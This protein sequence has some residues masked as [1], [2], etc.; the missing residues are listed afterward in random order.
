MA[1]SQVSTPPYSIHPHDSRVRSAGSILESLNEID[2]HSE[3][4]G[5]TLDAM[6]RS[7]DYNSFISALHGPQITRFLDFLDRVSFSR[8]IFDSG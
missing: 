1:N 3:Q 4:L 5:T 7:K 6:I 8:S 2:T